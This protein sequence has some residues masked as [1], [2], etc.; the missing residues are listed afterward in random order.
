MDDTVNEDQNET[1]SPWR[2]ADHT[3]KAKQRR[4]IMVVRVIATTR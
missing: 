3:I 2:K 4:G 1:P